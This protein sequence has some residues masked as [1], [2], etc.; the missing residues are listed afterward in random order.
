MSSHRQDADE[1]ESDKLLRD[2][3][4]SSSSING[5]SAAAQPHGGVGHSLGASLKSS[6]RKTN[7]SLK[8]LLNL[9]P[10]PPIGLD[11]SFGD[12]TGGDSHKTKGFSTDMRTIHATA[13]QQQLLPYVC[14]T[15][16]DRRL[17]DFGQKSNIFSLELCTQT[18]I[19][20]LKTPSQAANM[21]VSVCR[22]PCGNVC[23][24]PVSA[25]QQQ[26]RMAK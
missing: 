9:A 5:F 10:P 11:T 17:L 1:E 6:L 25:S 14:C 23:W 18:V 13:S 20:W 16:S 3:P 15:N 24:S 8:K 26:H 2:M 19:T 21:H 4:A 22:H 12:G 7:Q